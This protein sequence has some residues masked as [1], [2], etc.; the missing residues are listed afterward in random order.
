MYESGRPG[1]GGQPNQVLQVV[2][3]IQT[4]RPDRAQAGLTQGSGP[5]SLVLVNL[6]RDRKGK[7]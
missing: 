4:Q 7:T 5:V 6:G 3:E 1:T 2:L